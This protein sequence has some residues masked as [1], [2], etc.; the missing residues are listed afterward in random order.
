MLLQVSPR[1]IASTS[2]A[3][4]SSASKTIPL[5]QMDINGNWLA[6]LFLIYAPANRLDLL[7]V[8]GDTIGGHG[9]LKNHS[10]VSCAKNSSLKTNDDK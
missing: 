1:P 7:Y 4:V 3:T 5:V 2:R 9:P 8:K 10:L 6:A